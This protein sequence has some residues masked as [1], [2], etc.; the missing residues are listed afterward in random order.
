MEKKHLIIKSLQID[1]MPGF[2][3]GLPPFSQL[4]EHINIIS[5]P[6]ASGK[7]STARMIK[8]AL[9]P[10]NGSSGLYLDCKMQV[11]KELWNV[12][13]ESGKT[14]STR[15]GN[16]DSF[17]ELPPS[18]SQSR[19]FLSLHELIKSEDK[20][21]AEQIIKE[22][23]GGYDLSKAAHKLNYSDSFSRSTISERK[24]YDEVNVKYQQLIQSQFQLKQKEVNLSLLSS[25]R[26]EAKKAKDFIGLYKVKSEH[27]NL[28][29][30]YE[31]AKAKFEQFPQNLAKLNDSDFEQLQTLESEEK[32]IRKSMQKAETLIQSAKQKLNELNIPE[33]GIPDALISEWEIRI[34]NIKDLNR[35]IELAETKLQNSKIAANESLRQLD[36]QSD[37]EKWKG[38][39]LEQIEDI[40]K[41]IVEASQ[42]SIEA[43]SLNHEIQSLSEEIESSTQYDVQ[44]IQL[45]ISVLSDWLKAQ[46]VGEST[47]SNKVRWLGITGVITAIATFLISLFFGVFGI[48]PLLVGL[49]A[50]IFIA[51]R[52]SKTTSFNSDG[53]VSDFART[54]LEAPLSWTSENVVERLKLLDDQLIESLSV[55]EKQNELQRQK[56]NRKKLEPKL[57]N[58]HKIHSDLKG[59]LGAFPEIPDGEITNFASPGWFFVNAKRW[60]EAHQQVLEISAQLENLE[61]QLKKEKSNIQTNFTA[62]NFL[63]SVDEASFSARLKDIKSQESI[64]KES[65]NIIRENERLIAANQTQLGTLKNKQHA[66]YN[67]LEVEYGQIEIVKNLHEDLPEYQLVQKMVSET[68]LLLNEKEKDLKNHSL[69]PEIEP[70]ITY[71]Q[72]EAKIQN[73]QEQ[74]N[75]YDDLVN[76]IA[77]I[78]E[79][80]KQAGDRQELQNTLTEQDTAIENLQGKYEENLSAIT[81][82]LLVEALREETRETQY[83]EVFK[84]AES[85]FVSITGGKY[86]LDVSNYDNKMAFRAFDVSNQEYLQLDQLSSGTRIQLLLSV[87]LAFIEQQ[88]RLVSL[89]LIV[90]ELLANSDDIRARAIIDALIDISENGRQIFY[91]TAQDD[92]LA[93]WKTHLREIQ[94]PANYIRLGK[95]A[96]KADATETLSIPEFENTDLPSPASMSHA[97]YGQAIGVQRFNPLSD[98]ASQLHLWYLIDSPDLLYNCLR[99]NIRDLGALRTYLQYG[100]KIPNA[101]QQFKSFIEDSH[102]MLKQYIS[103][104]RFGRSFPIDRQ[105]LEEAD[106]VSDTYIDRVNDVL[107]S[108][109]GNPNQLLEALKNGAVS[110]FRTK[111]A[112]ELEQYLK[113][114][115]FLSDEQ[116]LSDEDIRLRL[117]AFID[118]LS[119]SSEDLSKLFNHIVAVVKC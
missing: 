117:Q 89:P 59:K 18:S 80:I 36:P 110:G 57:E 23:S 2:P 55:Q 26:D 28:L 67:R 75:Q 71:D 76:Q 37:P 24:A 84:K 16:P 104:Y 94:L 69:Y 51:S 41:F 50:M 91:F 86:K 61:S 31:T 77:S 39:N 4:S 54:G 48:I 111:K 114:R 22:S 107:K 87:R 106:A 96:E 29:S 108:V 118:D 98:N 73:Y 15:N 97:E 65:G 53:F 82:H 46:T 113:D 42:I 85:H 25:K 79:Q 20:H 88:E 43:N 90:D 8:T 68:K 83:P 58:L 66:I 109:N 9:W 74:A 72:I 33:N 11:D 34:E 38:L 49:F 116:P 99:K 60:Q 100:G 40:E 19:Y 12:K 7:T 78:Q 102:K 35:K 13:I 56:A 44:K 47:K 17:S 1:K 115:K 81:G 14:F 3:N 92:E 45:G 21:L 27:L 112:E 6:N 70:D 62:Y 63:E 10:E 95:E 64:R 5:G 52:P 93:K 30:Q 105:V 119:V 103:L 32:S 101:P